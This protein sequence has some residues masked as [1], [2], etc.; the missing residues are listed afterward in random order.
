VT[1][2]HVAGVPFEELLT[3]A[4]A[5]GAC[6]AALRAARPRAAQRPPVNDCRP[7]APSSASARAS[8]EPGGAV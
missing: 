8:D 1:F 2:A 6:W 7:T 5:A 4:P 3:L